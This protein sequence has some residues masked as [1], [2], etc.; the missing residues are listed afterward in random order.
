MLHCKSVFLSNSITSENKTKLVML[1]DNMASQIT[2]H[3]GWARNWK[4]STELE[5]QYRTTVPGQL[6]A[7]TIFRAASWM[8]KGMET[9]VEAWGPLEKPGG[10]NCDN[11]SACLGYKMLAAPREIPSMA[12]FS[13]SRKPTVPSTRH[14]WGWPGGLWVHTP[15]RGHPCRVPVHS[16]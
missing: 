4:S 8:L 16:A 15:E 13:I 1:F 6:A 9:L 12:P 11:M 5:I 3:V 7:G 14:L 2:N 10:K